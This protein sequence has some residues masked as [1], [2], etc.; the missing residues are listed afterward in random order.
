ME[1]SVSAVTPL[2]TGSGP[3]A[4]NPWLGP[5][6]NKEEVLFVKKEKGQADGSPLVVVGVSTVTGVSACGVL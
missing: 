4:Y 6:Q 5:E 1:K 2:I 3:V